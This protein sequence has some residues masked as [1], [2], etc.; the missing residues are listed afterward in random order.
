MFILLQCY[1][2]LMYIKVKYSKQDIVQ[3]CVTRK[4]VFK[5]LRCGKCYYLHTQF[6]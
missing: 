6:T 2:E 3:H 1:C 5:A 4:L